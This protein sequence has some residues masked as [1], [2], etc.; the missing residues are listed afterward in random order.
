MY[1]CNTTLASR[2]DGGWLFFILILGFSLSVLA[3][4]KYKEYDLYQ[5]KKDRGAEEV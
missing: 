5:G 4:V 2:L 3:G 1:Y